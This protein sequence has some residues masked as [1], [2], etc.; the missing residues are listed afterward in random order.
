[1]LWLG[2]FVLLSCQSN[3]KQVRETQGDNLVP[4]N[5]PDH[6]GKVEQGYI[7]PGLNHGLLQS[8][9]NI[10]TKDVK[11]GEHQI[12]LRYHSSKEQVV[13]LGHTVQTNYEGGGSIIVED[14]I[15]DFK[16]FHF[17]T[18]SEHHIDGMTYPLEMH[19]VHQRHNDQGPTPHYVVFGLLFRVGVENAFLEEFLSLLPEEQGQSI[20]V[21]DQYLDISFILSAHDL[22][23]CYHYKGSLTT[24]PFSETVHWGIIRKIYEASSEQIE[25]I[26]RLEG[27][28]ARHIQA[29]YGREVEQI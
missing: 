6:L 5:S 12:I 25:R 20:E 17:H 24:P 11:Q 23:G 8:P 13:N 26:N 16:Q 7:L 3:Q 18:P 21:E 14:T 22:E 19:I 9:I 27:N 4:A 1:M 28:N 15:Y 2:C 29:L 10:I